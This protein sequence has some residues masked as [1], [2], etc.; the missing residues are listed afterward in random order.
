MAALNPMVEQI[1]LEGLFGND[2]GRTG[3]FLRLSHLI[4]LIDQYN[5]GMERL[6]NG[7]EAVIVEGR[8]MA[9]ALELFRPLWTKRT[10]E[11][12]FRLRSTHKRLTRLIAKRD[13]Q[14]LS[15]KPFTAREVRKGLGLSP[16]T[17]QRHLSTL[18]DYGII[19]ICGGN[20]AKGYRYR[21]VEHSP[22]RQRKEAFDRLLAELQDHAEGSGEKCAS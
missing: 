4:A 5:C 13:G 20:R 12:H 18:R 17:L 21:L 2:I 22:P 19:E 10:D 8:H 14:V 9:L 11:L 15:K 6:Q 16:A 3:L 7:R 1:S